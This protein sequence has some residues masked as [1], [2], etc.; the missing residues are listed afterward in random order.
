[1]F[2]LPFILKYNPA[3]LAPTESTTMIS[4]ASTADKMVVSLVKSHPCIQKKKPVSMNVS[5]RCCRMKQIGLTHPYMLLPMLK[6]AGVNGKERF[7]AT[8]RFLN[9]SL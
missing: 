8:A 6:L 1:M 4:E 2:M 5:F 3:P 9:T 7:A